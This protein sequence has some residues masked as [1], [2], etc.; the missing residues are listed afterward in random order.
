MKLKIK[1]MLVFI[2]LGLIF[3]LIGRLFWKN[4]IIYTLPTPVPVSYHPVM[5]GEHINLQDKISNVNNKPAFIHFFNPAC[6]CSR[7]NI[8]H[9]QS[10]VRKYGD[11]I[12]FSIVVLSK[13]SKYTVKE[14][15]EKFDLNIP[16]LFDQSIASTCG[17]YS[18]P[19]AVI[20]D[21]NQKLFYRGNYNKSRYCVDTKSNFAQMAVDSLLK[22]NNTPIFNALA[23][24]SYGCQLPL[25]K[26]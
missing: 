23:T 17:V 10:L 12:N 5:P 18:T 8:P 2:W 19:Q 11:K 6:P 14:I 22:N 4:E 3:F 13:D 21:S 1:Y 7:F 26:K 20:I 24:T 16:V 15:Q 9:I 25:C